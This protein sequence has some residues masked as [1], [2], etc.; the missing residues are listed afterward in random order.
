MADGRRSAEN[1]MAD[2]PY[3]KYQGTALWDSLSAALEELKE[4]R[5]ITVTTADPYVIGYLAKAVVGVL[6]PSLHAEILRKD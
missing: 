3:T 4:N 2:F 6:P 5:D 1:N